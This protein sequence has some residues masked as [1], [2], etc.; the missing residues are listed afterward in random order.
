MYLG[1]QDRFRPYE[2]SPAETFSNGPVVKRPERNMRALAG[3]PLPGALPGALPGETRTNLILAFAL[4]I[5]GLTVMVSW[6]VVHHRVQLVV[7]TTAAGKT[8]KAGQYQL[9]IDNGAATFLHNGQKAATVPV[10]RLDADNEFKSN[11]VVIDA[12]GHS[13]LE[14]D[15]A[16]TTTRCL[17][18][19]SVRAPA[20]PM[21][22]E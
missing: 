1:D 12:D 18:V 2:F 6:K 3:D 22:G 10:Q 20:E 15:L 7:D 14:I 4:L 9:T 11:R 19:G 17:V 5:L 21:D 16:G 8:L 13:L